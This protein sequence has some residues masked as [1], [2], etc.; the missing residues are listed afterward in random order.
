M[1]AEEADFCMRIR[2]AG[3]SILFY[4]GAEI[5]HL[6]G[7]SS[8]K[9]SLVSQNRRI[10]SRL[11]LLKK[12]KGNIYYFTYKT[13]S[14]ANGSLSYIIGGVTGSKDKKELAQIK[15]KSIIRMKYI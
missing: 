11:K 15:I 13:L 14:L 12:H 7:G 10:V 1:Y 2:K 6:G 5:I 3:Y 8:Q 4:P 9:I